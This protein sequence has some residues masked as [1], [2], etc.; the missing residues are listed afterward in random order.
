MV[1][2]GISAVRRCRSCSSSDSTS[3]A[4]ASW[5]AGSGATGCRLSKGR[6]LAGRCGP[7]S[8]FW[9]NFTVSH[10]MIYIKIKNT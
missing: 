6:R 7:T 1:V 5:G 2:S 8:A 9:K 10:K 4:S 3:A